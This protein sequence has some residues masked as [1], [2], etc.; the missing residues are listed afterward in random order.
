MAGGSVSPR[1]AS[2]RVLAAVARWIE[3]RGYPPAY[4]ELAGNDGLPVSASTIC[5]HIR[6]LTAAGLLDRE[7]R[8]ARTLRVTPAGEAWLRCYRDGLAGPGG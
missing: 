8:Q 4:R 2:A 1:S 7:P 3:R 5:L 6:L